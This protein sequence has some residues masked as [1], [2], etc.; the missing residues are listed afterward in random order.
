MCAPLRSVL[1]AVLALLACALPARAQTPVVVGPSTVL[2][3][4]MNSTTPGITPATVQAFTYVVT[5]DAAP[6]LVTL[7]SVSCAITTPLVAPFL[8]M[9][10]CQVPAGQ[11]P[12][13]SHGVT[14]TA[15]SNGVTS[16]PSTPLQYLT[17]IIPV[18]SG[19][20]FK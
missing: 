18:P 20:F 6:P 2:Q 14:M 10:F 11:I 19:L 9:N 15:S 3:W 12:S 8:S 13:G 7:T 1:F 4:N 16:L 17:Y 5:V